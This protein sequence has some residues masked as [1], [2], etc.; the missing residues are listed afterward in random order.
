VKTDPTPTKYWRKCAKSK[1]SRNCRQDDAQLPRQ[2][3]KVHGLAA[4]M[5]ALYSPKGSYDNIF[6][7]N[8]AYININD[9]MTG[10]GIAS[11][12]VFWRWPVR[13]AHS[14]SSRINSLS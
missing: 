3:A 12:S 14:G 2:C 11:V 4:V 8:Y 9:Q 7:A 1:P 6:L 5:F 13:Y 10:E